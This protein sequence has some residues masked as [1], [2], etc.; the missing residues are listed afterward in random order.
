MLRSTIIFTTLALG[1]LPAMAQSQTLSEQAMCATQA[2]K[3]YRAFADETER[4]LVTDK[5]FSSVYTNHFNT[6]L[7][8]CF[9]RTEQDFLN[10]EERKDRKVISL[11][12]AFEQRTYAVWIWSSQ[13]DKK[14]WEVH[15]LSC[16]IAPTLLEEK[17]CK[18][19]EEFDE[20]VASYMTE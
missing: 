5:V 20:F 8:K 11:Y 18:T 15:P 4:Q 7:H 17:Y 10:L 14:Y 13:K 19:K 9:I 3:A 16:S 6:K 12:D 2:A 1:F